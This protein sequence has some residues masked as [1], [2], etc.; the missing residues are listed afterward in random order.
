MTHPL[1][2]THAHLYSKRFQNDRQ[3]MVE[4]A[5]ESGVELMLLP[6]IDL[7]SIAPMLELEAAFPQHCIPM[8]GLHPCSVGTDYETV[9]AQME[10]WLDR[11]PFLAV[12]EMGVDLYWDKTYLNEQIEAFRIQ[13]GWAK[14]R[15]LPIVIHCRESMDLVIDLVREL[16]DEN[17]RGVFHCFTGNLKQAEAIMELGFYLGIGGILTYKNG[18]IDEVI[19]EVSSDFLLLE[20]DAPYLA[21]VPHRGKRNESAYVRHVAERMAE[22]RGISVEAV[23]K[24]TSQNA[25]TLFELEKWH[26]PVVI[27]Q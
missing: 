16:H 26:N 11:R 9:L 1:V 3:V 19:R 18:G 5:I 2:D 24:M 10:V 17:L 22:I 13:V 14:E 23:A 12:G 25:K 15:K 7:E 6:N 20:T 27:N 21:P 4:R 8:M